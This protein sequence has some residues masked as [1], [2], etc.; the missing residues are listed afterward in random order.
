MK[1]WTRIPPAGWVMVG[2]GAYTLL[3]CSLFL[4]LAGRSG[5]TPLVGAG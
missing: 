4:Y 2:L 3:A 1:Y 5:F